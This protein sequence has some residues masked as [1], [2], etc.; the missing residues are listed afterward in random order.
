MSLESDVLN[1][2]SSKIYFSMSYNSKHAYLFPNLQYYA[3]KDYL[4]STPP[5]K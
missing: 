1:W 2:E 3:K 5:H 4:L